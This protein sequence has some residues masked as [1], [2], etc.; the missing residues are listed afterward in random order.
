MDIKEYNH[1]VSLFSLQ[2]KKGQF[3]SP[4]MLLYEGQSKGFI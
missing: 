3:L 2:R 4:V 1:K